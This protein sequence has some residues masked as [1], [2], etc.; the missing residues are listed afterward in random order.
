MV[1]DGA[2]RRTGQQRRVLPG[3]ARRDLCGISSERR[4]SDSQARTRCL[5]RLL[6][7]R[8]YGPENSNASSTG[9]FVDLASNSGLAGLGTVIAEEALN[10]DQTSD[11]RGNA[12]RLQHRNKRLQLAVNQL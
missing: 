7:Q 4:Q 8:I 10:A 5:R 9:A 12:D 3:Q 11:G 1:E 6:V 2:A